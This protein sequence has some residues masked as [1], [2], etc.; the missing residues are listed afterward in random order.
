MK[1]QKDNMC[2]QGDF[3][4]YYIM[5]RRMQAKSVRKQFKNYFQI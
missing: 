5:E 2:G 1:T 4:P 3:K